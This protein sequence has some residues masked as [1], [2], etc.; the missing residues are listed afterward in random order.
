ML[1]IDNLSAY[2]G[3]IQALSGVC[4]DV[5]AGRIVSIIGA[6]GAGKSTLLKSISGLVRKKRGEILFRGKSIASRPINLI[7]RLGISHVLEGRQLFAHLTVMDNVNLG[8]YSYFKRRNGAEIDRRREEVFELFPPLA[9][10]KKQLAGTLSGGEQ[11]MLAIG[12]ALMAKPD[13][14]LL[15]EPSLGLAPKVVEDIFGIIRT[16]NEKGTTIL[17]VEQNARQAL[18]ISHYAY[19]F[20]TGRIV[21]ENES[22][23][24]LADDGVR[25]AYLG[26]G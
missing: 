6:N 1:R 7:V 12:R 15:D 24:L 26:A 13:L 19:V 10:R 2:Y 9:E 20:E 23:L 25:R 18:G 21:L 22:P 3:S 4:L 11:Q 8:A 5:E 14:L 17:L 16:L